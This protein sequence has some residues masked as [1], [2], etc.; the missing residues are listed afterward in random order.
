MNFVMN[1]APGA[2]SIAWPV[3]QKSSVL[4]L[5]HGCPHIYT[6]FIRVCRIQSK[7]AQLMTV[8]MIS[9]PSSPPPYTRT[10]YFREA[11]GH[12]KC[13]A[14]LQV[15]AVH[16]QHSILNWVSLWRWSIMDQ[17][18]IRTCGITWMRSWLFV[19]LFA[20]SL[21]IGVCDTDILYIFFLH[22]THSWGIITRTRMC[23]D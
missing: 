2:G 5:Y 12:R 21:K 7:W 9:R 4:L 20:K 23:E 13:S 3:D 15:Y 19:S 10:Q 22:N 18:D 1:H 17:F 8:F 14:F 6:D 16:I 11:A